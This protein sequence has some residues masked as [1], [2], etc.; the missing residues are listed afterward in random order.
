[1]SRIIKYLG[2][3]DLRKKRLNL[4]YELDLQLVSESFPIKVMLN[5]QTY[6]KMNIH[7]L[8]SPF[9]YTFK[10]YKTM[11]DTLLRKK[12]G[13]KTSCTTIQLGLCEHIQMAGIHENP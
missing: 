13:M 2:R 7:P 12:I 9:P 1:M 10:T 3:K 4:Y 8:L 5:F 6:N 11:W